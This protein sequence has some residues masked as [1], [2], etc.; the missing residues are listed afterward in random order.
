MLRNKKCVPCEDKNTAPLSPSKILELLK[1]IPEWSVSDTNN[2]IS[3]EFQFEKFVDAI[4]FINDV[5]HIAE[6][7]GHHPDIHC[8][9]NKVKLDISTHSISGLTENDFILASKIDGILM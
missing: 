2:F 8:F 9:Y 3:K 1:E 5:A 7:E 4:N 6:D